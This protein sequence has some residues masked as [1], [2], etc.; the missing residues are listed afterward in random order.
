LY[1]NMVLQTRVVHY[2][3][4]IYNVDKMRFATYR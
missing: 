1:T 4:K 2:N 3:E